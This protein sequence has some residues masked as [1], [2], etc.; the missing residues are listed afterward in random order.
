MGEWDMGARWQGIGSV[1]EGWVW[2]GTCGWQGGM[3]RG[4]V[5]LKRCVGVM[6]WGGVE[7]GLDVGRG[8]VWGVGVVGGVGGCAVALGW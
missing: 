6:V 5:F 3:G 4:W 8:F 2:Y 1:G 7:L